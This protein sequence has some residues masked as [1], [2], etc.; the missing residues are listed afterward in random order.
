[1]QQTLA[2]CR[3]LC[4]VYPHLECRVCAPSAL[5]SRQGHTHSFCFCRLL[6]LRASL[7]GWTLPQ[8]PRAATSNAC[9]TTCLRIQLPF[10]SPTTR[11][12]SLTQTTL[13]KKRHFG[14]FELCNSCLLIIRTETALHLSSAN[15]HLDVCR[16]LVECQANV[17]A[18][19][20]PTKLTDERRWC[21][22]VLY[23]II[24]HTYAFEHE[25]GIV[26]FVGTL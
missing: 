1:M 13:K 19:N 7:A 25:G 23:V 8:R 2:D 9:E 22:D 12:P 21:E 6:P 20:E 3:L 24:R 14:F 16:L 10:M 18:A 4:P 11:T 15:G 5:Y 17:N 26:V